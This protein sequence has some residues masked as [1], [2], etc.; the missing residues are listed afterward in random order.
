V[1]VPSPKAHWNSLNLV[2]LFFFVAHFKMLSVTGPVVS[3]L[4]A[5]LLG[6]R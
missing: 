1:T 4:W 3:K 2:E 5:R 6:G